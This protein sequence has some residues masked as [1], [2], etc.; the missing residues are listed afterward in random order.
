MML[1]AHHKPLCQMEHHAHDGI[2]CCPGLKRSDAGLTLMMHAC[3]APAM[4]LARHG[5]ACCMRR[6]NLLLSAPAHGLG[7]SGGFWVCCSLISGAS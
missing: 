1:P 3:G 5:S 2:Y 6:S 7:R 4:A